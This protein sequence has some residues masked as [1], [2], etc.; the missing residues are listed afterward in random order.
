MLEPGQEV[1]PGYT[2]LD[3]HMVFDIKL[4]SLHRKCRLVADRHKSETPPA[5]TYLS[6]IHGDSV[7]IVLTL[8]ALNGLE[9]VARDIQNVYLNAPN[10]ERSLMKCGPEF[11]PDN[12]S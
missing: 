12:C 7:R 4:G 5:W 9:V 10:K 6:I 1:P 2:F 8:A 3:T 11:G